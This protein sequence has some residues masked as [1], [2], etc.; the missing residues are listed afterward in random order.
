MIARAL[1]ASGLL[2]SC[3]HPGPPRAEPAPGRASPPSGP[4]ARGPSFCPGNTE[5]VGAEPP[6]G[7]VIWC[8]DAD[9]RKQGPYRSWYESGELEEEGQY[10]DGKREG[11]WRF[12]REDGELEGTRTFKSRARVTF[13]VY[14]KSSKRALEHASVLV[15][16]VET[17]DAAAARTDPSGRVRVEIDA[18]RGRIE[19]IGP[20]PRPQLQ[21]DLDHRGRPIPVA[22][23][24]GP[25][26]R[27]VQINMGKFAAR[28]CA[29]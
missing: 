24:S 5:Q 21:V 1:A 12:Y 23:D 20:F 8:E 29:R 18:G 17:G 27:I 15:T 7:E 6:A 25:V 26:Q 11:V 28:S 3:S 13:C 22:L 2:L 9:G 19:V 10:R 16:N 4:V 14:E